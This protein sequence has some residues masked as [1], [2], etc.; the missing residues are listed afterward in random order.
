METVLR[1][2]RRAALLSACKEERTRREA[3][4]AAAPERVRALELA[5]V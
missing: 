2:L 5:N 3:T 1:H 4:P